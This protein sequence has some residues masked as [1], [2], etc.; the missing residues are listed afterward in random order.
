MAGGVDGG[1]DNLDG[2]GEGLAGID[3]AGNVHLHALLHLG[4]VGLRDVD[5][6][7]EARNLGQRQDGLAGIHLAVLEVLGA[8]DAGELGLDEGVLVEELLALHQLVVAG[9]GLVVDL[10]A[11][12]SCGF[13]GRHAVQLGLGAGQVDARR[14]ELRLVHAHE[15]GTFLHTASHLDIDVL[16]MTRHR[17]GDVHCLV[18]LKGRGEFEALG[19]ALVFEHLH[20][21]LLGFFL[22]R[23]GGL[24]AAFAAAGHQ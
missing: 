15:H 6:G 14:V 21:H 5:D 16:D 3:V 9:L 4:E 8:D 20:L 11:D 7:L 10:L 2:G 23:R 22:G 13:E 17:G 1:V 24:V 12:A 19:D 18:A